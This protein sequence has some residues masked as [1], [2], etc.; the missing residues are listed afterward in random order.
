MSPHPKVKIG[1]AALFLSLGFSSVS[2]ASTF[3]KSDV[4]NLV[5]TAEAW[6]AP[7]F[8]NSRC[9]FR[10]E[11]RRLWEDHVA[12][13]RIFIIS[14][15]AGLPD[16]E[17]AKQRLLKNQTDIGDF[18]RP[19]Y[20]AQAADTL[21]QLLNSHISIAAELLQAM[22][23]NRVSAVREVSTRWFSNADDIASA[24]HDLNP[25]H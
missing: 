24:L 18:V 21:T 11:M 9:A 8:T 19:Y 12:L 1:I 5:P 16:L 14:A 7:V 6:N 3:L 2:G 13:T 17:A 22:Q 25:D 23:K 4:T 15:S 10:A 20:G